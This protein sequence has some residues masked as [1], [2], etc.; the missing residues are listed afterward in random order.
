M[1]GEIYWLGFEPIH[2]AVKLTFFLKLS[3][4]EELL[5]RSSSLL[6]R[7]R[8]TRGEAGIGINTYTYT[9]IYIYIYIYIRRVIQYCD[10]RLQHFNVTLLH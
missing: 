2:V 3:L 8:V 6:L 5:V 10:L 7:G 1:L 4:L 9:Y